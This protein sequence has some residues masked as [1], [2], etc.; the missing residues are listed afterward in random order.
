MGQKTYGKNSLSAAPS[1]GLRRCLNI[2]ER[3]QE[4]DDLPYTLADGVQGFADLI[5][6]GVL[7]KAERLSDLA[8]LHPVAAAHQEYSP[9]FGRKAVNG[10]P[11]PRLFNGIVHGLI[12]G[13]HNAILNRKDILTYAVQAHILMLFFPKHI[14]A[15]VSHGRVEISPRAVNPTIRSLFHPICRKSLLH[16]ILDQ[17]LVLEIVQRIDTQR[18]VVKSKQRIYACCLHHNATKLTNARHIIK[19]FS[20]NLTRTEPKARAIPQQNLPVRGHIQS[21]SG[22]IITTV[23]II[24][25]IICIFAAVKQ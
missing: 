21:N 22:K 13:N 6:D 20:T 19:F 5:A 24:T 8:I 12:I 15:S 1:Q 16:Q 17:I 7:G 4:E 10:R 2:L 3:H 14:D 9:P 18:L 11:D 25:V 23:I